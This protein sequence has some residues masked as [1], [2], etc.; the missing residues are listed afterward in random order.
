MPLDVAVL[1][2]KR[3]ATNL[4]RP[5]RHPWTDLGKLDA[6]VSRPHEDVVPDLDA[7][8]DVLERNNPVSNLVLARDSFPRRENVLQYLGYPEAQWGGESVKDEVRI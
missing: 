5:H 3:A 2:L 8:L 1:V 4:E 6:V 7:V